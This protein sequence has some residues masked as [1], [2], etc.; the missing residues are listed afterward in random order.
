MSK[1]FIFLRRI[2]YG[3]LKTLLLKDYIIYMY[4]FDVPIVHKSKDFKR[5]IESFLQKN[6]INS[7]RDIKIDKIFDDLSPN[8]YVLDKQIFGATY[9]SDWRPSTDFK[10]VSHVVDSIRIDGD[11][12]Y[13]TISILDTPMGKEITQA[14]GKYL[15]IILRPVFSID[16]I[17][18]SFDIDFQ[19]PNTI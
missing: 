1:S 7:I 10:S 14:T 8:I 3:L 9:Q 19:Q 15:V 6:A 11:N 5:L 17:I 16:D 18:D 4:I 13:G 2:F 12:M